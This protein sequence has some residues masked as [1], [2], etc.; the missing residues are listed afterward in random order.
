LKRHI[1][2]LR[3]KYVA[4]LVS[5]GLFIAFITFTVPRGGLNW[6]IDFVG[7]V[8][9][10]A[11]FGENVEITT[12]RDTLESKNISASVQM[13]GAKE[14]NEFIISTKLLSEDKSSEKSLA[15]LWRAISSSFK[16]VEQLSVETVGPAIGDFLKK[17]ALKL[18]I[19]ALLMMVFYL[20]FR[21][22]LKFA[23]GAIVALFHDLLLS[24]LFCGVANV[25]INIPI[26]ASLLF[27][28]GYSVNDTIVIF[29]RIRENMDANR[30]G[31]LTLSSLIDNAV[32]QSLSRTLL[33]SLT[34]MVAVLVLYLWGGAAI[35]DFA[36]IILF[37]IIVGT[38]S[39][40]YIA[41]PAVMVWEKFIQK[42]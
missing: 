18:S 35:Q 25:E 20:S 42:K 23:I 8:K 13:I 29:D 4:A 27:I 17:S 34:T 12:I 41:S 19:L 21:F 39:S 15:I 22:E 11:K 16:N 32:N 9:I 6:G 38:Y 3:Y 28:F 5:L 1:P 7:G 31:K 10:T 26:I 40:I 30:S 33:T 2:F 14:K 36:F 24:L 37:G